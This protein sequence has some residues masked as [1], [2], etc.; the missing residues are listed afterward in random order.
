MHIAINESVDYYAMIRLYTDTINEN[1]LSKFYKDSAFA[2]PF[3]TLSFLSPQIDTT[4]E[5]LWFDCQT[6][7]LP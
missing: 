1:Y 6:R 5:E 2:P 3:P 7:T 4:I